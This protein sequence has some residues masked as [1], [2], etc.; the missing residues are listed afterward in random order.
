MKNGSTLIADERLR[1]VT[2]EGFTAKHD[3]ELAPGQ[4]WKAA[5]AY[6]LHL[7]FPQARGIPSVWPWHTFWWKPSADPLRNLVKAGALIAAEIDRMQGTRPTSPW[8]PVTESMPDD[9]STVVVFCPDAND[10]VWPGYHDAGN[11]YWVDGDLAMEVTHWMPMP[12]P[13]EVKA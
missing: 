3:A 5:C 8:I 7:G 2:Q 10:P 4:L 12:E 6:L 1:Q 13:P 11:W 9:E